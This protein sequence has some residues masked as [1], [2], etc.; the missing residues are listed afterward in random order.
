[1]RTLVSPRQ[2][3][4]LL[5]VATDRSDKEIAGALG[6]SRRTV[7]THLERF[8]RTHGVHSRA[9]A[10]ARWLILERDTDR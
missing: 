6:I 8:Y 9:A 7:R 3:D 10:V 1:M 2:T 4:I 5:L